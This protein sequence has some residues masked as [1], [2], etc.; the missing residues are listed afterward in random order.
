MKFKPVHPNVSPIEWVNS[1]IG[2][3]IRHDPNV[4]GW[5]AAFEEAKRRALIVLR[6]IPQP[7]HVLDQLQPLH[8][9][10]LKVEKLT[11]SDNERYLSAYQLSK[12]EEQ[13]G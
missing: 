6:G 2:C 3:S 8:D 5:P 13:I 11:L 10:V 4:V 9:Y 1:F 7:Y 12:S